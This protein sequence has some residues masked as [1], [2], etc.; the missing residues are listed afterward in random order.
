LELV[1]GTPAIKMPDC[2]ELY[3]S[4]SLMST[5]EV[6]VS[7]D[8]I[9]ARLIEE[10]LKHVERNIYSL[11]SDWKSTLNLLKIR[12]EK[13]YTLL[14]ELYHSLG[15]TQPIRQLLQHIIEKVS[16][17]DIAYVS[18]SLNACRA[19]CLIPGMQENEY[20]YC[21]VERILKERAQYLIEA[22]AEYQ[23][24]EKCCSKL[25]QLIRPVN[26]D[27]LIALMAKY[28]GIPPNLPVRRLWRSAGQLA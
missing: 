21:A 19:M 20:L 7:L 25:L 12:D 27:K 13:Y 22:A 28:Q 11:I 4:R 3:Y 18:L 1:L 15:D 14:Q 9:K 5:E 24:L 8:R 16:H 26:L 2:F 10:G 6:A 17:D 23:N